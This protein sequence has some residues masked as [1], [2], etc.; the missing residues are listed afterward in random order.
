MCWFITLITIKRPE[1]QR[2]SVTQDNRRNSAK[3]RSEVTF[4]I[5]FFL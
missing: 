3:L 1:V 4:L 5:Q 2:N